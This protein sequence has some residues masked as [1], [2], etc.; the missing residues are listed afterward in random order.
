TSGIVQWKGKWIPFLDALLFFG[1]EEIVNQLCLPTEI[2]FFKIDPN[3]L[4]NALHS[5]DVSHIKE[6][7]A[8]PGE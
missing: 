7:D 5:D 6:G 1:S 8:F 4:K 2:S 3:A